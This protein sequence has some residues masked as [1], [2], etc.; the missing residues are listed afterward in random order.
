[1]IQAIERLGFEDIYM[2]G[3]VTEEVIPHPKS[4]VDIIAFV[5][6]THRNLRT[7][8]LEGSAPFSRP[9]DVLVTN[10]EAYMQNEPFA[11]GMYT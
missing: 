10:R 3:S 5:D 11:S 6:V 9:C 4:D 7:E 2:R 1:M 8:I